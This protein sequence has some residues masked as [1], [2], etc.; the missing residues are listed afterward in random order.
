MKDAA[1]KQ[2]DQS[3]GMGRRTFIKN[4][5]IGTVLAVPVIESVTKS[6]ILVKSA[7][8]DSAPTWTI[9]TKVV[10]VLP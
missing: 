2:A 5:A 6:D 4:A 10:Q 1:K 3:A 9:T 8:A 7:L